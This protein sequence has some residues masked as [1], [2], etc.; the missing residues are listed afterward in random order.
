MS[1]TSTNA[2]R[3]PGGTE[4]GPESDPRRHEQEVTGFSFLAPPEKLADWRLVL[5]YEAAD[6]AGVFAALPGRPA[7]LAERC[8]L[9]E[10]ALHAVLGHL[11]AW[12]ILTAD[13]QEC[14]AE[15]PNAPERSGGAML[16]NHAAVIRRWAVLLGERLHDRTAD[17]ECAPARPTASPQVGLDLL[18]LNIRR[19]I[20]PVLD[21]CLERFPGAVRVLD[22]GG[23][24]G[25]YSLEMARRGLRPTMQDRPEVIEIARHRGHLTEAGVEL[26]AGDLFETLPPGPFDLVL[27][28][29]VT[30]MFD[31]ERNRDLYRRL[32]PLL[33]PGGGLAIVSYLRGRNRTAA[34]FALQMLA[35]TDGGDAHGEE[36]YRSWLADAGYGPVQVHDFAD[37]PQSIV[38]AER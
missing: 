32:R 36:D 23:G 33:A 22:L 9:D 15:G 26:F 19:L 11:A 16:L 13:E 20:A 38:L 24:H 2:A 18:A 10:G 17:S 37:P 12:G 21:V 5:A 14:Y 4:A 8:G 29:A 25:A 34:A 35:W 1:E 27:C 28:S 30:N 6:R 3:R 7:E 31:E